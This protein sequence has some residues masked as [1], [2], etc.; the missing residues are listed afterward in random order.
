MRHYMTLSPKLPAAFRGC[1]AGVLMAL[2]FSSL[3]DEMLHWRDAWVR[4][5]PP[6]TAVTAAYGSLMNHGSD[7]VTIVDVTSMTGAEA[8]MHDVIAD[9]DQRKMV[10]LNSVDIAPGESLVFEPG[11][12]HIMLLGIT[13][14]LEEGNGLALCA[15]SAMGTEACT[16]AP[17]TRQAPGE[18]EPHGHHH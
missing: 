13:E 5:L 11:G 15:L 9:G 16:R 3:A 1:A 2:S 10:R 14:A 18:T 12:R 6:G 17:V 4:S 7:T 8:Q